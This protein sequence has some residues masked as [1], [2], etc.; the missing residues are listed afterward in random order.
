MYYVNKNKNKYS[1][2][3]MSAEFFKLLQKMY[4]EIFFVI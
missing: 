3:K 1:D 4:K 2:Y